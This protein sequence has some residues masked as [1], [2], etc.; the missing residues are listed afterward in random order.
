MI[1]N[2]EFVG[3]TLRNIKLRRTTLLRNITG[4]DGTQTPPEAKSSGT[5]PY[6]LP[7]RELLRSIESNL[8]ALLILFDET[9]D[10]IALQKGAAWTAGT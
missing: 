7:E 4:T 6:T 10:N 9:A 2:E 5:V 3:R 8:D 1:T